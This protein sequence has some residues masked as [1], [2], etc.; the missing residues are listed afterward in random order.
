M[1]DFAN[2]LEEKIALATSDEEVLRIFA[3]AGIQVTAEALNG[4]QQ[5]EDGELSE[6]SLDA[7]S[8]GSVFFIVKKIWERYQNSKNSSAKRRSGGGR[9]G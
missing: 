8:G 1:N 9:N 4:G 3:D 2:E 6:N 5:A 7:V